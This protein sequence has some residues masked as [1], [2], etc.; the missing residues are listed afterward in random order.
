[1]QIRPISADK[2]Y[3]AALAEIGKL[4]GAFI[5]MPEGDKLDILVTYEDALAAPRAV[6]V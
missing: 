3:G 6:A 1:M 4:W 5:V 2:D